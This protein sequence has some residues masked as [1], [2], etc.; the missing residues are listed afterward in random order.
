MKVGGEPAK[1]VEPLDGAGGMSDVLSVQQDKLLLHT[2][3][4]SLH[5]LRYLM[6]VCG[7]EGWGVGVTGD[8]ALVSTKQ[9]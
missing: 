6:C 2:H 4:N 1:G 5:L 3:W 8:L 9:Y 7:G